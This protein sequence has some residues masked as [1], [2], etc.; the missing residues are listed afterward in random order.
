MHS[1]TEKENIVLGRWTRRNLDEVLK[2]AGAIKQTG[3]RI[4]FLSRQFLG[5][6][7]E[8]STLIGGGNTPELFTI[9]LEVV[10]CF[11]YLDYVEAMRRS[12]NF[13]SFK[14]ML[15]M[16]RYRGGKVGYKTRNHFFTDWTK[17][18][19][20]LIEVTA[21]IGG[22]SSRKVH[23]RLNDRGGGTYLLAGI[24]PSERDITYIPS[25]ALDTDI[26]R[27]LKTGDYI[28]IYS[29]TGGLDVSHVGIFVRG[30]KMTYLR[31]ASSLAS[32][33]RVIDQDFRTYV[34]DKPGI[35]VLRPVT[36]VI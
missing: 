5:T 3:K 36:P 26:F 13:A 34:T 25:K 12:D 6:P 2:S 14:E 20:W 17:G 21:E 10:D 19:P 8:E 15:R 24:N 11:T 16:V 18:N 29:R 22:K 31:H 9:N 7:Y 32:Q 33:R 1:R 30:K 28:G 35:V 23:K 27:R 4:E